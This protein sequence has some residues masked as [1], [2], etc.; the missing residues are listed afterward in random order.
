VVLDPAYARAYAGIGDVC[1]LLGVFGHLEPREAFLRSR[2]AA[3]RALALDGELAEAHATLAHHLFVYEWNWQAAGPALERAIALDP[4]YPMARMFHASYLHSMGRPGE[5][6]AEIAVA[7]ALDPLHPAAVM[8]GR[9]YVD[10][11]QP[12]EAIRVLREVIELD[13]RRDLAHEL[14]AHACLQKGM[15][16]EAV[17]SMQRAAEL[18][19]ARDSAQLAFVHAVSGNAAEARNVLGRLLRSGTRLDLLGFH[20][21]MACAGLG[22]TD[23]AFRWLDAACRA[24]GGFMNLLAVSYGFDSIRPDPRFAELLRRMGLV[25]NM[26]METGQ[27]TS[28]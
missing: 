23:E 27:P 22:D 18:S 17:A 9:I 4:G 13:P 19:G 3:E 15:H 12:D 8:G 25:P 26:A 14:L 7:Q 28:Q 5:A 6:L 20:L 1:A 21:A 10:T 24:R 2:T 16:A 11:R